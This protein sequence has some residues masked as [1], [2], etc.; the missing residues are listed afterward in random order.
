MNT[1]S[2]SFIFTCFRW[3]KA[4]GLANVIILLC[5]CVNCVDQGVYGEK[6]RTH[7]FKVTVL[8]CLM[9]TYVGYVT[10]ALH[11]LRY[12]N[13]N[14]MIFTFLLA[15]NYVNS[16]SHEFDCPNSPHKSLTQAEGS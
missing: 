14:G 2:M 6:P 4:S 12:M 8:G 3:K 1:G 7:L 11:S 5:V 15:K 10:T 13:L 9:C 16:S